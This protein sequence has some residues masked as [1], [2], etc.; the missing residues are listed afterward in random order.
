MAITSSTPAGLHV[1]TCSPFRR[2]GLRGVSRACYAAIWATHCKTEYWK[3]RWHQHRLQWR[4]RT[5]DDLVK[6]TILMK[7]NRCW[8]HDAN[9]NDCSMVGY[10]LELGTLFI[11]TGFLPRHTRAAGFIVDE[12]FIDIVDVAKLRC[13]LGS[14]ALRLLLQRVPEL[15]TNRSRVL[16]ARR[17][18]HLG[19]PVEILRNAIF[20]NDPKQL[21]NEVA[22]VFGGLRASSEMPFSRQLWRHGVV[23]GVDACARI[24]FQSNVCKGSAVGS[25]TNTSL[26]AAFYQQRDP[27]LEPSFIARL[28]ESSDPLH[29]ISAMFAK[30]DRARNL[31]MPFEDELRSAFGRLRAHLARFGQLED[32]IPR[33]GAP[34]HLLWHFLDKLSL[35]LRV[36]IDVRKPTAGSAPKI[37]VIEMAVLPDRDIISD[38]IRR[39]ESFHCP[40]EFVEL[41]GEAAAATG[42][43]DAGSGEILRVVEVGG[44]LGDCLLW[45]AAWLGP[46][47]IRALELEPVAAATSRLE[48]SLSRN[49]LSS[50]VTVMTEAVGD[51]GVHMQQVSSMS[52]GVAAPN[53]NF[54]VTCMHARKCALRRLRALDEIV[55]EWTQSLSDPAT[56]SSADSTGA[57]D[58]NGGGEVT[59]LLPP[60]LDVSS[61]LASPMLDVVRVKAAG[62]EA[63]IVSGFHRHLA[64]RRVRRLIVQCNSHTAKAVKE[65]MAQWPHYEFDKPSLQRMETLAK[66]KL[67]DKVPLIYRLQE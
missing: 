5:Y 54:A 13:G 12:E 28:G 53:P 30:A 58:S 35:K 24:N 39:T 6:D 16:A 22:G 33:R 38:H 44:F 63:R 9:L 27:G 57:S 51:G 14:F 21:L 48:A 37:P 55:T 3:D 19:V 45:A 46:R 43:N 20:A 4:D 11:Y 56:I 2:Q 18:F 42:G 40:I 25:P 15:F 60:Q 49:G 47:R 59:Q 31:G 26:L 67:P 52:D 10:V 34:Q 50:A 36:M 7:S 62:S 64:A 1:D 17:G 61:I 23:D 8:P 29:V 66:R 65:F 41:V 32:L